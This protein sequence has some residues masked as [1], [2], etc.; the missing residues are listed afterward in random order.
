[1]RRLGA[2]LLQTTLQIAEFAST[3]VIFL[4]M[5]HDSIGGNGETA[6]T[7]IQPD[8]VVIIQRYIGNIECYRKK[9][10][11][12]PH[13]NQRVSCGILHKQRVQPVITDNIRYS[14][15]ASL[16]GAQCNALAIELGVQPLV[17]PHG[18]PFLFGYL[19]PLMAVA[20]DGTECGYTL[21][22]YLDYGLAWNGWIFFTEN[23]V[24]CIMDRPQ[25]Y[26]ESQY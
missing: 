11:S 24:H 15:F 4:V 16:A 23:I 5:E 6:F 2:L 18:E 8:A 20:F 10:P 13:E 21:L 17:Q 26:M 22:V 3:L 25:V 1:M 19:V 12:V 7:H 14:P 9:E